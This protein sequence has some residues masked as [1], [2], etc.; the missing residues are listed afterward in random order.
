M[1][2]QLRHTG[3]SIPGGPAITS[4]SMSLDVAPHEQVKLGNATAEHV[5]ATN[6]LREVDPVS[7]FHLE[8]KKVSS[9][10]LNKNE[11]V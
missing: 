11:L 3:L 4:T 2:L 7:S 1:P 10:Q 6:N 8:K 9:L 5:V